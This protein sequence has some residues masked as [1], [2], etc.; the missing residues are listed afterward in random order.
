MLK[1]NLNNSNFSLI[2][3]IVFAIFI[4]GCSNLDIKRNE[5]DFF[6]ESMKHKGNKPAKSISLTDRISDMFDGNLNVANSMGITYEVAL[7]QF[8][9]MPLVSADKVGGTI[10]TDWYSAPDSFDERFKFNIFIL[11]EDMNDDSIDIV[12]FKEVLDGNLWKPAD[13]N[14]TTPLQIEKLILEKSKQLKATADLS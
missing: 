1:K 3:S 9:I 6:E 10:I 7:K 11:N 14:N 13:I 8:S 12:M 2:I 5:T 4:S